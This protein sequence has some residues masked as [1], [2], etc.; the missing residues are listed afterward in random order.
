MC[1]LPTALT[2]LSSIAYAQRP[3]LFGTNTGLTAYGSSPQ[4]SYEVAEAFLRKYMPLRDTVELSEDFIAN[5]IA[6]ALLARNGSGWAASVPDGIFL[7]YVL[8]YARYVVSPRQWAPPSF[9]SI[10]VR[11]R[12]G[13][14]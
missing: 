2:L 1:A 8:P 12:I 9:F 14:M 11:Y 3:H 7:D 6:A 13:A 5:N 10:S 4:I